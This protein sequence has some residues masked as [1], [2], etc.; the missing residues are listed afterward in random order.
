MKGDVGV[1]HWLPVHASVSLTRFLD[2]F[3]AFQIIDASDT[4]LLSFQ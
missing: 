1:D 4:F 3:Q 2:L